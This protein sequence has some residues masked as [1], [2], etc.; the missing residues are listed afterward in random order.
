MPYRLRKKP[1]CKKARGSRGGIRENRS[2]KRP[3][4]SDVQEEPRSTGE[5]RITEVHLQKREREGKREDETRERGIL[6]SIKERNLRSCEGAWRERRAELSTRLEKKESATR[7]VKRY[8]GAEN[9]IRPAAAS[10]ASI[11]YR[12]KKGG[13]PKIPG[14]DHLRGVAKDSTCCHYITAGKKRPQK[15]KGRIPRE[16]TLISEGSHKGRR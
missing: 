12:G 5:G 11:Q 7:E 8:G 1:V 14:K 13:G 15:G 9:A 4:V 6:H 10:S 2:N 3:S 16:D